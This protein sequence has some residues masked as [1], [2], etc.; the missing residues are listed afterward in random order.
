MNATAGADQLPV[1]VV[2]D[3][4]ALIRTLSDILRMHGYRPSSAVTGK[5]GLKLAEK[6]APALAIVDLRLPDMD[7][8]ELVSRLHEISA[9]T[10]VVVLT[11]NAS[12]ESAV[13]ALREGSVDY[14]LKPVQVPEFL[15][16]ANTASER[17]QRRLAERSLAERVTQQAAVAELGQR[18]ML[19][20][21]PTILFNDAIK[22]VSRTLDL[23]LTAV[24]ERRPD[25][26]SLLVKAC[27][28]LDD[29]WVDRI[30]HDMDRETQ[31][32]FTLATSQPALVSDFRAE[33]AFPH[34]K[35]L[36]E[37]GAQSGVTVPI[38]GPIQSY[39]V[40]TAHARTPREFTQDD[41]HF[42]QAIAHVLGSV[43]DRHRNEAGLRQS[44]RME[45][46]GRL[47]GSVAHDFN[48]ML[49]AINGYA[50]IVRESLPD[51]SPLRED[52]GE[53]IRASSRAAA[54]T[55]Q[56]LA[57]SR[58]QVLQPRSVNM[59]EVLTQMENMLKRLISESIV[60]TS[61]LD[62]SLGMIKADPSQLEQVILNLCVNA[63]DAMPNGGLL[64][65]ETTNVELD[66][67]R[68][69][70]QQ[71]TAV[72]PYVML[73]VADTG[74]GMD[75]AT[76]AQ[77]FEPFFTTKGPDRGTGLGLATVYGIVKQSGGEIW[78][79]SELGHGT[80]FK[81]FLPRVDAETE[82]VTTPTKTPLPKRATE[83][84]LLAEDEESVRRL[85]ERVLTAA[86]FEV[87]VARDGAEAIALAEKHKGDIHVLVTDMIMPGVKGNSL[88]E[89]LTAMR[90]GIRTLFVSGF[91]GIGV[92][93]GG[94]L[95]AGAD[96]LQKPFAGATLVERVRSALQ[97]GSS[98]K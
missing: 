80:T 59:N 49:T 36:Q 15:R 53:I 75:A 32:G 79:Y 26:Q 17:W 85:S 94:L 33:G 65:V 46:V 18:A 52:V 5:E 27:L 86:G 91:T 20:D 67:V 74:S 93:Q 30:L 11:G 73:T 6:T 12:V 78:V 21:N 96:F 35:L 88:A 40:L 95:P 37:Q 48:N 82:R 28:G 4:N 39:G 3:D 84:V 98:T 77:I 51:D 8:M 58:Q 42:L 43:V 70:E 22:L 69:S 13:S 64:T 45:A 89:Q 19:A 10:E 72:G 90:P 71:S 56:L 2:D 23:P 47:A 14:L 66:T 7:G 68:S 9:F 60:Y 44:Q 29:S 16:V 57:F 41:V 24:L 81:V 76:R 83:T 92:S 54:L 38:P 62:K 55:K 61:Y 1:L 34:S 31:A 25:G 97:R 63:R 87:L 50:D